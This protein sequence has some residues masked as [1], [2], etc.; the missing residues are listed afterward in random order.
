MPRSDDENL[1]VEF[2]I[3][4]FQPVSLSKCRNETRMNVWTQ[5][6]C[7]LQL[8]FPH[9]SYGHTATHTNP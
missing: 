7:L 3:T 2:I 1:L 9:T 6:C 8:P 4:C 5:P